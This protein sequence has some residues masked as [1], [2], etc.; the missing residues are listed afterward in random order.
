[1][2]GMEIIKDRTQQVKRLIAELAERHESNMGLYESL[3]EQ[4]NEDF[5]YC[6]T[7]VSHGFGISEQW[8]SDCMAVFTRPCVRR[9]YAQIVAY[10]KDS[11][12]KAW[13][14]G[15][16]Q[17]TPYVNMKTLGDAS[18]CY[19]RRLSDGAL[20]R[21]G[22]PLVQ[23]DP[24]DEAALR[25]MAEQLLG[26][27]KLLLLRKKFIGEESKLPS[28]EGVGPTRGALPPAWAVNQPVSLCFGVDCALLEGRT[29]H[30]LMETH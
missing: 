13:H 21:M 18:R 4:C 27:D 3:I 24:H 6:Q 19:E 23:V 2:N 14:I 15:R 7:Q 5:G 28:Y 8:E 22:D 17:L 25:L 26:T 29:E 20:R 11:P 30:L 10:D 12:V 9:D 1:M 16:R